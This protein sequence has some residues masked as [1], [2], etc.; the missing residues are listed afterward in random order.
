MSYPTSTSCGNIGLILHIVLDNVLPYKTD[1]TFVEVGANDGMTGSFTYNLAKMGWHGLYFEPVPRIYNKCY[2]NHIPHKNVKVFQ[3]GIGET[4]KEETIVDADTLSTIDTDS[5]ES[6]SNIK[7]F[8]NNFKNNNTYKIKIEKLDTIL[9][10]NT[11]TDIDIL[12]IDVEGYEENVLK[13]FTINKYKPTIIIIE[14]CDQHPD[15]INNPKMM[16]K[17]KKLRQYFIENRYTLLVNDIVDNVYI[18]ND[19]HS[20]LNP[21]F[22][23]NIKKIINFPQF[24]C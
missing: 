17:Y 15:F 20:T 23:N 12:V 16:N 6:Y 24:S 5:I 1:G 11:V 4:S 18:R 10:E 21:L 8:S 13:G 3:L 19:I 2:L 14:I 9:E 7:Q 22:V